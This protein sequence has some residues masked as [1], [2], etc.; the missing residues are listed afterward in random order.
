MAE[1]KKTPAGRSDAPARRGAAQRGGSPVQRPA[2]SQSRSRRQ[3]APRYSKA[4][5]TRNRIIA[6][7]ILVLA[8][9]LLVS[10]VSCAVKGCG[11]DS[12]KEQAAASGASASAV[13]E[14]S[15]ASQTSQQASTAALAAGEGVEDP[16]V[17]GGRFTTG[18]DELDHLVKDWCDDN[19][20]PD[21]T[22]EEN[23]FNA[24][25]GAMWKDFI[26]RDNNQYPMG[27]GWDITYAKQ[28]MNEGGG[29]C[30][31]QAA[32]GEFIL[33]YFGY[34]EAYAEPCFILRQSGEYGNHGLIYVTDK[35]GRKCLCDPAFGANG[36]M[37]DADIYKVKL[38]DI[39][40]DR[41]ELTIAPFE[42]VVP[43]PWQD[44]V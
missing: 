18:D 1:G 9:V 35:D 37:L 41:S 4:E 7:V 5:I 44:L 42:E 28:I 15:S 19:S 31:E 23:A 33:K 43:A 13:A 10:L 21:L 34:T 25:C 8:V 29:N 39:G 24:Y 3:A 36:W 22:R 16:W 32:I 17:E 20:N 40:Q 30:Y 26:E 38:I 12:A 6:V 14:A 11:Q 27:V 2:P